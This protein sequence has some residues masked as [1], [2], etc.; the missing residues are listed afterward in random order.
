MTLSTKPD[1][2]RVR[3]VW[4]HFWSGEIIKR[5]P[6]VASAPKPGHDPIWTGER[7]YLHALTRQWDAQLELLD[8]WLDSTLFLAESVPHFAPDHGPD[9]FAAFLGGELS[10]SE[11]SPG[12]NWIEPWVKDW[13]AVLP[14]TLDN[15]N[16]AWKNIR[17]YSAVLAEHAR[18]RYMVGVCD[19]HSNMD[20]LLAMRGAENLSMD[21]Y[22]H[23][24]EL[25]RA[26]L[27]VRALYRPIYD[28]LYA[29]GGM[30][31]ESGTVGWIP[32]WCGGRFATIQ[33]DYLCMVSPEFSRRYI[34]PALEEEASFLDRCC[35]HFDGPGALPHLDDV[36]AIDAIDCI[37]WVPGA[38]QPA[39]HTWL[40]VLQ[41][42][43]AAGKSVQIYGAGPEEI[44]ALHPHL[45]PDKVFYCLGF[46]SEA[47]C[48][49]L[50]TW[51]EH[52]T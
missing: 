29:A 12:T 13:D 11:D 42:C 19:L 41:R 38:G 24:G 45:K 20:A 48:D 33:C 46:D 47:E 17:E 36:L 30:S 26:M 10:F 4:D 39:M 22:D 7:R 35:L 51:L 21:F 25:I 43:Q 49:E 14:I 28:G 5:P 40:D 16:P 18:G 52:N 34:L 50:L 44:K 37:Q 15:D 23:P 9:Q 1:L 3:N 32:G 6:V 31:E 8:R 2:D 27:D